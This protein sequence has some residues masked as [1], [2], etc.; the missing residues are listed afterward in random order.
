M[1]S[2]APIW[3]AFD[4][5]LVREV[6]DDDI[7]KHLPKGDPYEN[8]DE[9]QK[10]LSRL[11]S[12]GPHGRQVLYKYEQGSISEDMMEEQLDEI[13]QT[14]K[15]ELFDRFSEEVSIISRAFTDKSFLWGIDGW[16][17]DVKQACININALYKMGFRE[18]ESH[19]EE[20]KELV[21]ELQA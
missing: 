13:L 18:P 17:D 16:N 5:G 15:T 14:N 6:L 21:K 2:S 11:T 8:M 3:R 20:S 19:S 12:V 7:A 4:W 1:P 10:E 9:I